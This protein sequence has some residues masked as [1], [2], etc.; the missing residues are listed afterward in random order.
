MIELWIVKTIQKLGISS[1]AI[2]NLDSDMPC[3]RNN[4]IIY[5]PKAIGQISNEIDKIYYKPIIYMVN[6]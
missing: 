2:T 6:E 3:K 1:L 4:V 5:I